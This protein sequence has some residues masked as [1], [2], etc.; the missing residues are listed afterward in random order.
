[1]P[2]SEEEGEA[3]LTSPALLRS[4]VLLNKGP[5][6]MASWNLNYIIN[7]LAPSTGTPLTDDEA[8]SQRVLS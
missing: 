6:K 3:I 7:A 5:T 4:P 8:A 2:D 1:M